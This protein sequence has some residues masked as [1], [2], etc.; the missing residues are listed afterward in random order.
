MTDRDR[1]HEDVE[2]VHNAFIAKLAQGRD[3]AR[4]D[5]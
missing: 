1:T 3:P 2:R 4:R 5:R